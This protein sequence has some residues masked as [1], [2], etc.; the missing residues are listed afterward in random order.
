MSSSLVPVIPSGW[1]ESDRTAVDVDLVAIEPE[2]L[3]DGEVL[4]RER[5]IDLDEVE[6]GQR[7]PSL[8]QDF[9]RRRRRSHPHQR[10]LHADGRPVGQ[11]AD[12][13]KPV[14]LDATL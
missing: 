7:K 4:R 2:L 14:F 8:A 13:R 6:I 3:F 5:L 9:L 11:P 10:R 12:R 1:P